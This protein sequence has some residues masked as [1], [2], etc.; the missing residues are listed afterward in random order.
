MNKPIS[1][2]TTIKSVPDIRPES[3][4]E[5]FV[6]RIAIMP[7]KRAERYHAAKAKGASNRLGSAERYA[8]Y[9][10][11]RRTSRPKTDVHPNPMI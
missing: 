8:I 11:N 1:K 4:T 7:A 2:H 10:Q 3:K 9:V 5:P 6:K